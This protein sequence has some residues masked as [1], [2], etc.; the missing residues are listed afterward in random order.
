[1]TKNERL[2]NKAVYLG[3]SI[4]ELSKIL[5]Y[6]F[7]YDYVKPK[8]GEKA[9]YGYRQFHLYINTDDIYQDIAENV[10]TRLDT[11]NYELD[12]L[13]SK[14]KSKKVIGLIG[15]KSLPSNENLNLKIIKTV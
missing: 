6:E 4:L 15:Q 7:W 12:R 8:Y 2:M 1:M 3:L 14:V 10:E 9:K 13:L 11:L 5:M